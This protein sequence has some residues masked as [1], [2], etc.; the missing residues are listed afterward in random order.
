MALKDYTNKV[1]PP[2]MQ[3]YLLDINTDGTHKIDI[4]AL[5]TDSETATPSGITVGSDS[6]VLHLYDIDTDTAFT[7]TD[8]Y[9]FDNKRLKS[10]KLPKQGIPT[11]KDPFLGYDS[12]GMQQYDLIISD[13]PD[14]MVS[15]KCKLDGSEHEL[16]YP[17]ASESGA[18][19]GYFGDTARRAG[20]RVG[21]NIIRKD[22]L[23]LLDG[24]IGNTS[25]KK[26]AHLFE[27][28]ALTFTPDEGSA[29]NKADVTGTFEGSAEKYYIEKEA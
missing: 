13:D 15:W 6:G 26:I 16:I 14:T 12:E 22:V 18:T 28:V 2:V 17:K 27:N 10:V 11:T 1:R 8:G 9:K 21:Q 7:N 5:I 19:S 20:I 23:I 3:V 24:S 29:D 25:G 4:P